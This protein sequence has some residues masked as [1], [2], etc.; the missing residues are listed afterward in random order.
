VRPS[1]SQMS[2]Y[3]T[4]AV[5]YAR[6]LPESPAAEYLVSRGLDLELIARFRLGY[7]SEPEIGHDMFR[8][9]L[10]V[11]YWR[12]S[13]SGVWSV[14]GIKFRRLQDT[15]GG[16]K[17]LPTPGFKPALFNTQD[18]ISNEDEICICEGELDALAS[19]AYGLPA[20]AAPGATTWQPKWNPI[21][22]GYETIYVLADGDKAGL[23]FGGVVA[24]NLPNV[25]VVPMLEGED[26]NSMIQKYGIDKVKGMIGK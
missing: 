12:R 17:Y 3:L 11:P 14:R 1:E 25:K 2:S 26:V 10:S 22:A 5:K 16:S 4:A 6:A 15:S 19:S 23:E 8:G 20:V 24:E 7:V 21:F 18:L 9:R 13:A